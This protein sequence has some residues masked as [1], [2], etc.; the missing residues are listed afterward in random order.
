MEGPHVRRVTDAESLKAVAH[1]VRVKLLGS[2]RIDGPATASELGRRLGESSGSTSYH[3]RQLARYGFIEEDPDQPN[4]RDR[5][6]RAKHRYTSWR[7]S[8]FVDEPSGR[9]AARMM[10]MR[11][12]RL[13]EELI[14]R[15]DEGLDNWS[16]DWIDA[17]GISDE[18]VRLTPATL[19]RLGDRVMELAR[20]Y[21]AEDADADDAELVMLVVA[22]F[23]RREATP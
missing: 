12:V 6:W 15:F 2:L 23:P 19:Q 10:R 18:V 16:R 13:L 14:E 9:E 17:A 1:P 22:G 11:Q 4:A 5:R 7:T 21:A 3:L 20:E 8:D